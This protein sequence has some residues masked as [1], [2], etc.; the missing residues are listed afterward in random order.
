MGM[1]Y[2]FFIHDNQAQPCANEDMFYS[3]FSSTIPISRKDWTD[4]WVPHR[5][6]TQ[7]MWN[8]TNRALRRIEADDY[9]KSEANGGEISP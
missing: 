8:P 1:F 6:D 9:F 5:G 4:N 7:F 3:A 2:T